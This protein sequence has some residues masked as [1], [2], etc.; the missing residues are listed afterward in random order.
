MS[1]GGAFRR[2]ASDVDELSLFSGQLVL[3]W[4]PLSSKNPL[5][6]VESQLPHQTFREPSV[7]MKWDVQRSQRRIHSRDKHLSMY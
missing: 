1:E 6:P 3:H 7:P 4:E 5:A 2:A